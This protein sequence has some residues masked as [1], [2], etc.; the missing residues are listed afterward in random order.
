MKFF[1]LPKTDLILA[2]FFLQRVAYLVIMLILLE[3]PYNPWDSR[4]VTVV[5]DSWF[6]DSDICDKDSASIFAFWAVLLGLSGTAAKVTADKSSKDKFLHG[7]YTFVASFI[8]NLCGDGFGKVAIF[9]SSASNSSAYSKNGSMIYGTYQDMDSSYTKG[10]IFPMLV[11]AL[12]CL[13]YV[14]KKSPEKDSR[15]DLLWCLL[16]PFFL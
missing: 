8:M 12:A 6:H 5:S 7:L 13:V 2:A 3:Q 4:R 16:S 10:T 1:V 14:F 11:L 15:S 9:C